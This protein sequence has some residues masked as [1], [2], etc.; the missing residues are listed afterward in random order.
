MLNKIG[1]LSGGFIIELNVTFIVRITGAKIEGIEGCIKF[2]IKQLFV[3]LYVS[4]YIDS[5]GFDV[6][7]SYLLVPVM[8]VT[9]PFTTTFNLVCIVSSLYIEL[10]PPLYINDMYYGITILTMPDR[11]K[12][13]T[14][15]L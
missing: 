1:R 7:I 6:C 3:L 15:R 8:L 2:K 4:V 13:Y 12:A 14:L 5:K 11:V 10:V 9:T